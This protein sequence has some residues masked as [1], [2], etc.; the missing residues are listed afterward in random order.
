MIW[1]CRDK[2]VFNNIAPSHHELWSWADLYRSEF[3][4]M[5]QKKLQENRLKTARWDPP[6]SDYIHKLN[7]AISQSKKSNSVGIG[8]IIP[9]KCGEVLAVA[10]ERSVKELHPLCTTACVLRKALLFCQSI[11][12]SQ[13]QVECN[14]VEVVELLNSN[15]ICSLEVAWILDD[16]AIIKDSFNFISFSSIPLRCNRAA[17]VLANAVKEKEEVIVWLEECPSFLLPIVQSDLHQ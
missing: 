1:K 16:I 9:N 4:E 8:L 3:V 2:A 12:F 13:V 10:C 7:V 15:R 5:Q 11:S 6:Q 17:I 14:F